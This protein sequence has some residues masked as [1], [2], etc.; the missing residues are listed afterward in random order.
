MERSNGIMEMGMKQLAETTQSN[1]KTVA[2]EALL[3]AQSKIEEGRRLMARPKTNK[4]QPKR[5]LMHFSR[6]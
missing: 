5:S 4:T 1:R 3:L 6:I 2:K